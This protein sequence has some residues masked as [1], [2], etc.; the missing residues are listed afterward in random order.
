MCTGR[1]RNSYLEVSSLFSFVQF[2]SRES[3]HAKYYCA[4]RSQSHLLPFFF[5]FFFDCFSPA[6]S[7]P[8]AFRIAAIKLPRPP[9]S[10]GA[11]AGIAGIDGIDGIDGIAG[12]DG[13]DGIAA[14]GGAAAAA[15]AAA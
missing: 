5:F 11:S 7:R 12:I 4:R 14:A 6:P 15:G 13:I 10:A 2:H 1:S 3:S 8:P 9:A